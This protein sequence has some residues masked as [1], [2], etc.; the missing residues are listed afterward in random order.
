MGLPLD[1]DGAALHAAI[2]SQPNR[3]RTF[4]LLESS[5]IELQGL[6]IVIV[7][8]RNGRVMCFILLRT[9]KDKDWKVLSM[10]AEI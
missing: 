10:L 8:R 7:Y 2:L 5:L 1:I 6:G 3:L 4:G 9:V